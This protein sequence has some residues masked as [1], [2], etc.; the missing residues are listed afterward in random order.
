MSMNKGLQKNIIQKKFDN[1]G[2]PDADLEGLIDGNLSLPENVS[3]LQKKG[4]LKGKKDKFNGA[5]VRDR[6]VTTQLNQAIEGLEETKELTRKQMETD[7]GID[8]ETVFEPP[9]TEEEFQAWINNPSEYDIKGIDTEE[10]AMSI[11]VDPNKIKD[12]EA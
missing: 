9:L 8:A 10:D 12:Y 3:N 5:D 1:Q 7:S 6:V 2:T 4:I 11:Q